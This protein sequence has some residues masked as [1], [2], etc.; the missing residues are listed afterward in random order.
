MSV[1]LERGRSAF[2]DRAWAQASVALAEAETDEPLTAADLELLAISTYMLGSLDDFFAT[3]ERAYDTWLVDGEVH[4]AA[5]CAFYIGVTSAT[6]GEIGRAGGWFGRAQRLVDA[7][8]VDCV[9]QGYLLMPGALR[10]ESEG[11]P[12]GAYEVASQAAEVGERFNDPDLFSLATHTRGLALIRSGRIADGLG[13]LD[14]AMLPSGH[15][16]SIADRHGN[17]L[18]RLDRRVRGG[19]RRPPCARMDRGAVACGARR[20]P[21]WSPS[22]ARAAPIGPS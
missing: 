12:Q 17:R 20:S 16:R 14:E 1:A 7:A 21:S 2:A 9:E 5:R 18:L 13:L 6:R 19:V 15:G 8:G 11:D 4:R 10:R 22:A 3:L